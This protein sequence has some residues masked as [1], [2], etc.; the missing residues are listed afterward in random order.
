MYNI[1]LNVYLLS[2]IINK[3]RSHFARSLA[4]R[5]LQYQDNE[6]WQSE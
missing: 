5:G 4:Q 3:Q 2:E 6:I 1:E